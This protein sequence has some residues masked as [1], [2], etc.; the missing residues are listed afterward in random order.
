MP[1][2]VIPQLFVSHASE[3]KADF[4]R[5]LAHALKNHGIKVWYDEFSL[6][7]GDSLRRSIDRGLAECTAGIV[8][9]SKSFFAKEWPQRELDALYS[10]EVS[11]RSR[12][13]P[14]WYEIDHAMVASLSP[15]LA[16]RLAIKSTVGVEVVAQMIADQF[17]V[18]PRQSG[19][20]LVEAL[21]TLQTF[22]VFATEANFAGCKYRF[23]T[24][25]AYK[26]EYQEIVDAAV[27]HLTAEELEDFPSELDRHLDDEKQRLRRKYRLPDDIYL[28]SDEP[29]REEHLASYCDAMGGWV[30]GTLSR[31]ES[32]ELVC[33]LDFAELDEYF[34]LLNVPNFSISGAQRQLLELAL[35]ELGCGLE[36]EYCKVDEI[37]T[38]LRALDKDATHR[39]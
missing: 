12:I 30:S 34:I 23:L 24:M 17:E 20:E 3:D 1:S 22:G 2:S 8:V 9:L 39:I 25:N 5:P 27:K 35:I 38:E 33:D 14:V 10:A 21:T 37:C 11:G 29:I 13:I 6:K 26:E 18:P 36:N 15:L 4:V 31:D 32:V 16:D 28:T 19:T 7:M